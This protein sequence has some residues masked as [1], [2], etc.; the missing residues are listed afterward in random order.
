M[1]DS[2]SQQFPPSILG[3][4]TPIPNIPSHFSRVTE[5]TSMLEQE[6]GIIHY[7]IGPNAA[8]TLKQ[9][10]NVPQTQNKSQMLDP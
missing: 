9:I 7:H 5:S 8:T 10:L 3:A 4:R 2:L 1:C 6:D